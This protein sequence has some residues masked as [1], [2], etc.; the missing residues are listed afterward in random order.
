[1]HHKA[2]IERYPAHDGYRIR[3]R[4]ANGN[5]LWATTEGYHNA[6][7]ADQAMISTCEAMIVD[8]G[9]EFMRSIGWQRIPE[10][11]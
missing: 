7:D 10:A 1:M 6:L 2:V 5:I 4:A 9:D 11:R 8:L 3:T